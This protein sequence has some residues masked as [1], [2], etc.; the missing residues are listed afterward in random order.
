MIWLPGCLPNQRRRRPRDVRDVG[1]ATGAVT[2]GYTTFSKTRRTKSR[3]GVSPSRNRSE[4]IAMTRSGTK[5]TSRSRGISPRAAA[6]SSIC[7]TA[8]RGRSA[9][10]LDSNALSSGSRQAAVTKPKRTATCCCS[11]RP[12]WGSASS[13]A[14]IS[15]CREPVSGT[16][17]G[18]SLSRHASRRR[19]PTRPLMASGGTTHPCRHAPEQQSRPWSVGHSPAALTPPTPPPKSRR[20]AKSPAGAHRQ[21]G[22]ARLERSAFRTQKL[23]SRRC[24]VAVNDGSRNYRTVVG[25]DRIATA[26]AR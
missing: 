8:C 17:T 24:K 6:R 23:P 1:R 18:P 11:A 19:R 12:N 20:H 14:S 9:I 3:S 22:V 2:S 10:R 15:P 25:L 13:S 5:L 16:V 21:T 7:A 4:L 26:V